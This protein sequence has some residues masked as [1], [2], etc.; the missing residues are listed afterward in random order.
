MQQVIYSRFC[1]FYLF[2]NFCHN[3]ENDRLREEISYLR[4]RLDEMDRQL[5]NSNRE[6]NNLR[7]DAY[8]SQASNNVL[9]QENDMVIQ[10]NKDLRSEISRLRSSQQS[11]QEMDIE[12]E[13][14]PTKRRRTLKGK[15]SAAQDSVYEDDDDNEDARVR[16]KILQCYFIY[17]RILKYYRILTKILY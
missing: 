10:E 1:L 6:L 12:E 5:D 9:S 17:F 11:T 14:E 3:L 8:S 7:H 15:R 13:G 16:L 2:I 4:G